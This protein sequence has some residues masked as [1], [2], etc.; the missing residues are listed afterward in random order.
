LATYLSR[1]ASPDNPIGAYLPTTD[2]LDPGATGVFVYEVNLG[3]VTLFDAAKAVEEFSA[4]S[5][6]S[7]DIGEAAP[8]FWTAAGNTSKSMHR[9]DALRM[10]QRR[11]RETGIETEIGCHFFRVTGIAVYLMN[12]SLLDHAQ[13]MGAHERARG[14]QSSTIRSAQ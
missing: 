10:I 8:L 4:I 11:A 9:M 1:P 3:T 12:G 7:G 5:G 13:Q 2:K 6:L 14:R